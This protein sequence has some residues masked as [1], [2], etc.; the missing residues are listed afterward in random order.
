MHYIEFTFPGTTPSRTTVRAVL[1]LK[2]AGDM[3]YNP[4]EES[5][6]RLSLFESLMIE[7]ERVVGLQ[8]KHSRNVA[9]IEKKEEMRT[10]L[11]ALPEGEG[12]DGIVTT[13]PTLVPSIT[14][15]DCMPIY[16]FCE[17]AGAFGVLHSGWRGT[18]ILRTAVQSMVERYHCSTSDISVIF[19]PAIGACCYAVDENRA[20]LFGREFGLG[21]VR[22]EK[23]GGEIRYYI[24]LLAANIGLA[25][26]LGI[27]YYAA[28]QAC[29]YCDGRFS[30]FRRDGPQHFTRM[31]ALLMSPFPN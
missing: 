29:T 4:H 11:E 21:S 27:T 1:S 31:L 8:L 7:P 14:V 17:K 22:E 10:L 18:G 26:A 25:Q 5:A 6:A 28:V 2:A 3:K 24:D 13:N 9:F 16:V 23:R 19:G 20:A 12:F 30:S 15:A